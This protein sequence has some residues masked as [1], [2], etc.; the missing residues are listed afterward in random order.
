MDMWTS[1]DEEQQKRWTMPA[2]DHPRPPCLCISR[3]GKQVAAAEGVPRVTCPPGSDG[4]VMLHG[5]IT[6]TI[7]GED[8]M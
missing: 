2:D 7:V 6:G 8:D 4:A 1:T 5:R 3:P